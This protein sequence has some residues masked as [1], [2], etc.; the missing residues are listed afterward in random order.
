M[1]SRFIPPE[2]LADIERCAEWDEDSNDWSIAHIACAGNNVR[3]HDER[4]EDAANDA[5]YV[6]AAAASVPAGH[7][8][9]MYFNYVGAASPH[10]TRANG[11]GGT[12]SPAPADDGRP[13]RPQSS[14]GRP[15]SSAGRKSAS[16]SP[17]NSPSM[18]RSPSRAAKA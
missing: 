1:I 3:A 8:D 6:N 18:G 14:R 7:W 17:A 13:K 15:G 2:D 12:R 11:A 16:N 5:A 4:M 9:H 10:A